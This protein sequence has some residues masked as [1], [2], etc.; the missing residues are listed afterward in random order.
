MALDPQ[1]R[2]VLDG[3]AALGAPP[4]GSLSPAEHR[5][6]MLAAR[7]AAPPGPDV[8]R[9]VDRTVPG[10]GGDIPVR[11]YY[12][13]DRPGLPVLVYYHGGGWVLG[14][15]ESHDATC[16]ELAVNAGCLVVS[17]DYRLAP[18]H[19]FPAASDDCYAATKWV[20][21]HAAEIGADASQLAIGG[22]SAGG[23]LAAVVALMAKDR[24]GPAIVF[25]L[26][27]YPVTDFNL[28]TASYKENA[29][30]YLL[31]RQS[32]H[33][34]WNH[35]LT[36]EADGSHPHASPL[37]A[38]DL[39]GLPPALVITAEYDPLRDEGEAYAQRLRDGGV[40]VQYTCYPG[41]IHGFFGMT[42]MM[43]KAKEAV[44]QAS[45]A[46]REAFAAKAM[47]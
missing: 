22:D 7:A 20:A 46:L 19:Q 42:A 34:F 8:A 29:E 26:L 45:G 41:M 36:T 27:I 15:I 6:S 21:D 16:R 39:A 10:P 33:W 28:D 47:A 2:A 4:L 23:N 13:V 24:G 37:R 12:P 44:A 14:N 18:E 40:R 3:M 17:V 5:A 32:M 9:V 35:Y 1:A 11:M 25:Q 30:G 31:T 38:Q 43:D